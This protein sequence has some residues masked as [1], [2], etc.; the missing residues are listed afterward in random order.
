MFYNLIKFEFDK[1]SMVT[2]SISHNPKYPKVP[3]P[4]ISRPPGVKAIVNDKIK[5]NHFY[6]Q[7][8]LWGKSYSISKA[9]SSIKSH[10]MIIMNSCYKS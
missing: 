1:L 7:I 4:G 2:L 10:P 8:Q 6:V 9:S 5:E 3:K